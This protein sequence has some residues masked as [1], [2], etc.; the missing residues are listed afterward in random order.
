MCCDGK[1]FD[2]AVNDFL[3]E[4]MVAAVVCVEMESGKAKGI[5]TLAFQY[6]LYPYRAELYFDA[7]TLYA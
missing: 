7:Q 3:N 2:A 1:N 4:L 6:G 5:G